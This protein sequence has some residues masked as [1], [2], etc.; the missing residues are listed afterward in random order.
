MY[1]TKVTCYLEADEEITIIC[2]N[3]KPSD[4]QEKFNRDRFI[5][6]YDPHG[7]NVGIMISTV[8]A[9]SME[10]VGETDNV[11]KDI[12]DAIRNE[13]IILEEAN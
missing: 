5:F 9:L 12:M 7:M 8:H 3:E 1:N 13:G 2:M 4:I 6:G 10:V 11:V